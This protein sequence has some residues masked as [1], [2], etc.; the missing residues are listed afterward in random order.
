MKDKLNLGPD[1]GLTKLNQPPN[2]T[3]HLDDDSFVHLDTIVAGFGWENVEINLENITSI[4]DIEINGSSSGKMMK[5]KMKTISKDD[6][7]K[8]HREHSTV[9]HDC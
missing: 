1:F 9:R 6:C 2:T 4:D 7:E 8:S 5:L 3:H